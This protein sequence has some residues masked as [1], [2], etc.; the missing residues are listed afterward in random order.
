MDERLEYLISKIR[1]KKDKETVIYEELLMDTFPLEN[2]QKFYYLGFAKS[3]NYL[4]EYFSTSK[5]D[6]LSTD[7]LVELIDKLAAQN[8][9]VNAFYSKLSNKEKCFGREEI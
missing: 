7:Q 5:F 4:S 1:N 9:E 3:L 2:V 6:S 8:N